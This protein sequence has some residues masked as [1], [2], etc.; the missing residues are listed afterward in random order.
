MAEYDF[1]DDLLQI[2][3]D[4]AAADTAR[5]A[6]A[7]KSDEE[8]QAAHARVQKL[9]LKLAA[10]E[11]LWANGRHAARQALREAVKD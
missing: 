4:F 11:W 9:A 6:A 8:F 2:G 5:T 7:K 3:R 10:N 1:P